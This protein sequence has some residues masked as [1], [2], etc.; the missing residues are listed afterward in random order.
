MLVDAASGN[1]VQALATDIQI[2]V[3]RGLKEA[4]GHA[5]LCLSLIFLIFNDQMRRLYKE[6]DVWYTFSGR[7]LVLHLKN[8]AKLRI[9]DHLL[10]IEGLVNLLI[11]DIIDLV[12]YL[13]GDHLK[14]FRF[15]LA[16]LFQALIVFGE[17]SENIVRTMIGID[18]VHETWVASPQIDELFLHKVDVLSDLMRHCLN[19]FSINVAHILKHFTRRETAG[20]EVLEDVINERDIFVHHFVN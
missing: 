3:L 2:S 11:L 16:S 6:F 8:H 13:M 19:A 1:E 14:M 10:D 5:A 7:W 4:I 18:L 12:I 15:N 17:L 9:K 20:H